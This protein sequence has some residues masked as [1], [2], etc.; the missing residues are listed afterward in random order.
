MIG[1]PYLLVTKQIKTKR[2]S[3]RVQWKGGVL[4][5]L[6]GDRLTSFGV[7]R[8]LF[9]AFWVSLSSRPLFVLNR[10]RA[11]LSWTPLPLETRLPPTPYRRCGFLSD[12]ALAA[13]CCM[14]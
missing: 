6:A 1:P 13:R 4:E 11:H 3:E 8:R 12:C 5:S 7:L 9:P 14:L 10:L 2:Q